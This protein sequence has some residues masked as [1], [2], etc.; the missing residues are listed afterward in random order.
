MAKKII[1]VYMLFAVSLFSMEEDNKSIWDFEILKVQFDVSFDE[2]VTRVYGSES[3]EALSTLKES[4]KAFNSYTAHFGLQKYLCKV[5]DEK[6]DE[7][8]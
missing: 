7:A 5:F 6:S 4:V 8:K 1:F 2:V 3:P